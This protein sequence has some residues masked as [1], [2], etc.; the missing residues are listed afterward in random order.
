M[1]FNRIDNAMYMMYIFHFKFNKNVYM[2]YVTWLRHHALC[3]SEVCLLPKKSNETN[4]KKRKKSV[5]QNN[6]YVT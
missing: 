3:Q 4:K 5:K 1:S 6:E 2:Y